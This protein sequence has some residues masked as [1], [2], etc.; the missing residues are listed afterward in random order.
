VPASDVLARLSALSR[1][2]EPSVPFTVSRFLTRARLDWTTPQEDAAFRALMRRELRPALGRL[3]WK[4]RKGEPYREMTLRSDLI[5]FLALDAADPDVLARAAAL[6]KGW[7]AAGGKVEQGGVPLDLRDSAVR[8]AGRAGDA[9]TFDALERILRSSDD[10]HVRMTAVEGLAAFVEP[11][12]AARAQ[13]LILAPGLHSIER[14]LLI[15]RHATT[16]ELR[17]PLR[18]WIVAHQQELPTVLPDTKLHRL[19]DLLV[20]CSEE[21]SE[22]LAGSL[23][24]LAKNVPAFDY[25]LRKAQERT[26][27]CRAVREIQA[28]S[29]ASYLARQRGPVEHPSAPR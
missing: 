8:A 26:R 20:G 6:G 17:D 3:G 23:G 1:D 19:P 28:P 29:V 25:S 15:E 2:V 4:P 16:P 10:G 11:G 5:A 27:V 14:W 21:A 24:G 7:I 22:Q 13:E 9:A 18:R 12:L